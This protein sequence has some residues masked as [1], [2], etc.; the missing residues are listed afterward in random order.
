MVKARMAHRS[1]A[2]SRRLLLALVVLALAQLACGGSDL[3][4][5]ERVDGDWIRVYFTDPDLADQETNLQGGLDEDLTRVLAHAEA[6]VDAA[7]YHL[8]LTSVADALIAAHQRGVQV[9]LVTEADNADEQVVRGL[10]EVGVAVLEDSSERGLMHNKFVVID[11]QWVW[12]GSWNFTENGT[13]RNNNHA[14]LIASPSLAENYTTEF[15]EM[16]AGQF[17][18]GSKADTPHPRIV[19]TARTEGQQ[20][21]RIEMKSYFAPEDGVADEIIA[22]IKAARERI[23]FLAFVFTS[24]EI[25]A[26]MLER[27]DAGVVVQGVMESRNVDGQYDQY[28]H[29]KSTV[30]D[31]LLDGNP[32]I[33]HHKLIIID[34]ETVI[35]GSY[36]FTHSAETINDE[37]TLIIHDAQVAA[38]FVE[39]FGRMYEQAR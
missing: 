35:L 7:A 15:E 9:R 16:F 10:Q 22:Q 39:E 18:A 23:R 32:Y 6:S 3:D 4:V 2:G 11:G 17:G 5:R 38:L 27:A 12:T 33:M 20:G 19:I 25:A 34:D 28:E 37:N 13:Y 14:V 29:L 26:A 1:S 8:D 24:E 31:V 30:H 36:N 21:R